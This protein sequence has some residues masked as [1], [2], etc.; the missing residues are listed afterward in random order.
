MRVFPNL[1]FFK[2]SRAPTLPTPAEIRAINEQTGNLR[3]M[4]SYRPPPVKTPSLKLVVKYGTAVTIVEAESQIMV[5]ERLRG[6]IPVPEVFGWTEDS[7]QKFIYKSLTEGDTL[8][9]E[10]DWHERT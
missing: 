1:S 9:E 3:A 7:G 4:T 6:Q 5:R 2:E 10:I 8:Q